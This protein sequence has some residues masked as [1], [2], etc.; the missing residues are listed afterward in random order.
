[1]NTRLVISIITGLGLAF[2]AGYGTKCFV[3]HRRKRTAP[4][5]SE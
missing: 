5:P 4:P 1:M 2:A 3:T